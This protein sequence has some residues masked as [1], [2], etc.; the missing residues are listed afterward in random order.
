LIIPEPELLLSTLKDALVTPLAVTTL[1]LFA[2]L[3]L[4]E[5]AVRAVRV[6]RVAALVLAGAVIGWLRKDN[7]AAALMPLPSVLLEALAMV[8]MFEVGQ[9]VP[10]A[11][12]R[13]NPWLLAA[14]VGETGLTF[15]AIFAVLAYGFAMPAVQ[16]IVVGVIC[17]GASPIVVMS[18]SKELRARGQVSE[19]ALLFST[20]SS[21]YA[22]LAMQ[23]LATAYLAASQ[24][25][26]GVALQP[27]F[28]LFGSFLL[29]ALA[30][31]C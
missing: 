2:A 7:E 4:A 20:L 22:V 18:V 8:L 1:L 9:R 21:V 11:W 25:Q 19:R 30:A 3:L 28:Q 15:G 29:G 16:C 31:G 24:V 14:S 13:R 23:I 6:P 12:I 27:L 10:L 5:A 26:L 17:M